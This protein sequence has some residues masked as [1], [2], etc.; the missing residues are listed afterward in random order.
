MAAAPAVA[1]LR[2]RPPRRAAARSSSTVPITRP[3][4]DECVRSQER[5]AGQ[6]RDSASLGWQSD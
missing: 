5:D 2:H 6:V 4:G 1:C 3:Q